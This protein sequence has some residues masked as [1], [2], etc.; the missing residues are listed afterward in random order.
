MD[1]VYAVNLL[2]EKLL[3]MEKFK[4]DIPKLIIT[5]ALLLY[6]CYASA[7]VTISLEPTS[8]QVK[9]PSYTAEVAPNGSLTS[10][11]ANGEEFLE[12]KVSISRG[13]YFYQNGVVEIPKVEKIDDQTIK[14]SSDK[15]EVKYHFGESSSDWTVSNHTNSQLIFFIILNKQVRSARN[16][17]GNI[18]KV[19]A[20]ADWKNADWY[21][22]K[23]KLSISGI[24]RIWGP[25]EGDSQVVEVDLVPNESKAIALT[26]AAM[27]TAELAAIAALPLPKASVEQPLTLLS[28]KNYQ[29]FQRRTRTEGFIQIS[30][31]ILP[32]AT[33]L[34]ARITG[35][36][37][38][39]NLNGSWQN[40][41]II[42]PDQ[43]FNAELKTPA[44]GWYKVEVRALKGGSSA[45][46][47]SVD[48][49]GVGEVFVGAGQSNSTNSGQEKIQQTSGMVSAFSGSDWQI[50]NDPQPGVH[51][52]S[53]G[54][55][56]WPAFGDAMYAKYHV[57]IGVAVTGH[58]GT[59]VN[60][61]QADGE[62]FPWMMTRI[63]QL[64]YKG[65]RA[66]L[67]HQGESDTG[68][69]TEEYAKKLTQIIRGSQDEASWQFPWFI[70]QVSYHSP[71]ETIHASTR[72]AQKTLWDT[73]VALEGP[74]TDILTGD[75]RDYAGKGIHFSPKGLRAHG[76]MWAEKVGKYL[77]IVLAK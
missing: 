4:R 39:G 53:G 16:P 36:P 34:E 18:V 27:S 22:D 52:R 5:A 47:A 71:E 69:T 38:Q 31:R 57:P 11:I 1:L 26:T 29:V 66:V 24:S 61:W 46:E 15:A 63:R 40:I 12:S 32:Q 74:D 49:V 72:D 35:S 20:T 64:G 10:F 14:A 25:W 77:D 68:M 67:W 44:G 41:P 28:P 19:P 3:H 55:S 65:F 13:S 42:G 23:S 51:D 21:H 56:F 73:K 30:G 7:D 6:A 54:G 48:R 60:Q 43:E 33:R 70:A 9:T 17:T 45:A 37:L 2:E 59:S 75:N 76:E 62:L 8:Y 58:G 50:A